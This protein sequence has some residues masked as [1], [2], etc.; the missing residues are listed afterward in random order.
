M[1]RLKAETR[2]KTTYRRVRNAIEHHNRLLRRVIIVGALVQ[3]EV[4]PG[5]IVVAYGPFKRNPALDEN[6]PIQK[7]VPC[8]ETNLLQK[9]GG[10]GWANVAPPKQMVGNISKEVR[11]RNLYIFRSTTTSSMKLLFLFVKKTLSGTYVGWTCHFVD[12]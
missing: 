7:V 2:T 5:W 1:K 6:R 11:R 3:V 12:N 10:P 8:P 9:E 4:S